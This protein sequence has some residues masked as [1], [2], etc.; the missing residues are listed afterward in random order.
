MP[1]FPRLPAVALLLAGLAPLLAGCSPEAAPPE[2]PPRVVA[3]HVIQADGNGAVT[4]LSGR[5][6]AAERTAL[7]FEIP[8]E[9]QSLSVDVGDTFA[10]GDTLASLDDARY[11]LV[12]QQRRAERREAE[13]S[14]AEKRQD[15]RRQASLADKGY[16]SDTRL[17]TAR[18]ALDTAESRHASAQAAVA[19][20]ERDLRLTTLTAP[21]AGSVSQRQAEPAERVAANQT[22]LE[23]IS[24]R[25]GFEV[26]TSVPE[27]LVGAL[28]EGNIHEV[29]LPALGDASSPATLR[30]LGT[31]PRSSNDYPVI[32]AVDEPPAGLRSGMTARVALSLPAADGAAGLPI[33]LT[34]LVYDGEDSAHVLRIDDDHRLERVDVE[35]LRLEEGR[36]RVRGALAPGERIVARGAEF[37]DAGQA[38]SLL[39]E[40]PERYH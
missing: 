25:E 9:I 17:D 31:Q 12:A 35:V 28:V 33:P 4:R 40:G 21:Y 11:R 37:V 32:L 39:G 18:A 19:L 26:E 5:V 24:D 30:R 14:L 22:V 36:A 1:P 8:G 7:S 16:V 10:A 13:A 29:R 2:T 38:V 20:A 6:K 15:Y 34:A 27:T 23:V 3:S